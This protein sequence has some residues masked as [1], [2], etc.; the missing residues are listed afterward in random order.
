MK[1]LLAFGRFVLLAL[2]ATFGSAA[3]HAQC[4]AFSY[5]QVYGQVQTCTTGAAVSQGQILSL[6]TSNQVVP[7]AGSATT[8]AYG[9]A[10]Q[11]GSTGASILILINGQGGV[12]VDGACTVGQQ[13]I[14][15]STAGDGHCTSSATVQ[16]VGVA[17][18]ATSSAASVIAQVSPLSSGNA[19]AGSGGTVSSV[20]GD[21][22][23]I[24]NSSSTG[25]V[26]LA[27]GTTAP[28]LFFGN[29]TGSTTGGHYNSLG[30]SDYSP[31]VYVAGGG[32]AQAQT[33]TLPTPATA[34][35]AGLSFCWKPTAANTAA[36]P[37]MAVNGLTA[38]AITKYGTTALA[39]NDLTTTAVAC[40]V[41]DGTEFQLQN[42]QTGS[43]GGVVGGTFGASPSSGYTF[44]ST[45][46]TTSPFS[47]DLLIGTVIKGS[48]ATTVTPGSGWTIALASGCTIGI[49]YQVGGATSSYTA[50]F[51]QSSASVWAS[52]I[53]AFN[54]TSPTLAQSP[55]C[56]TGTNAVSTGSNV[57][58]GQFGFAAFRY[59]TSTGP[60]TAVSGCGGTWSLIG[61]R[62]LESAVKAVGDGNVTEIWIAPNLSAGA[63]TVT[64]TG[65][66]GATAE[67]A[68]SIW[69]G[70]PSSSYL[71]DYAYNPDGTGNTSSTTIS[72]ATTNNQYL[73]QAVNDVTGV[74]DV[75]GRDHAAVFRTAAANLASVGGQLYHKKGI[76]NGQ[77]SVQEVNNSQTNWYVFALPPTASGGITQVYWDSVGETDTQPSSTNQQ[78]TIF[79][80]LPST[81]SGPAPGGASLSVM[82]QRPAPSAINNSVIFRN[83]SCRIPDNQRTSTICFDTFEAQYSS[84]I[85]TMAETTIGY[86][87]GVCSGLTAAAA[88]MVGYRSNQALTNEAYFENTWAIGWNTP[89]SVQSN[90]P[91]GV[92]MHSLCNQ[93]A[94]S[95]TVTGAN[96]G[97]EVM[98]FQDI[99][100]ISG[101]TFNCTA[102]G[103]RFIFLGMIIENES[104]GSF[105]RTSQATETTPGNCM[106]KIDV[107]TN[108]VSA[109]GYNP[110]NFF[111]AG[112][113]A[114][115]RV[116]EAFRLLQPGLVYSSF[117]SA[118]TTGTTKQTLATYPFPYVSTGA[119][120]LGPFQNNSGAVFEI[121]AWGITAANANSKTYEIDFGGTA[122]A[123]I[124]STANAGTIRC[125]ARIIVS[126]VAN[127]Q[128]IEGECDDGTTRTVTRIAPGITGSATIVLNIAA[129]TGTASGDFTFKGLTVEYIGGQ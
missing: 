50:N 35:T 83:M 120:S 115:F 22:S 16:I 81:Y 28:H 123:T 106:G 121:V 36:A 18:T 127:T 40:V 23:L 5:S 14:P 84:H 96:Y 110:P 103:T 8:G 90:H 116:N 1:K 61:L 71:V 124:T 7:L 27:L 97:G 69:T 51:T 82:Y 65:I 99:H 44:T 101:L 53:S 47:G 75:S 78:G 2:L 62:A 45:P 70:V 93:N 9:I 12:S 91:Y 10:L 68:I 42:P 119:P 4:S 17:T 6:N 85:N 60:I 38:T 55:V 109:S 102:A 73:Y 29:N 74:V 76:Y 87:D 37:T 92:N 89:Y 111:N 52:T 21:G 39:A 107:M 105:N 25:A 30:A 108:A 129:T 80:A 3:A 66:S 79:N 112:S 113:G 32:T 20:S 19:N 77:T 24:T 95:F 104:T 63:C 41:Y 13:I 59:T 49:E 58:A 118:A 34:L 94:G 43:S 98:H 64:A 100:N 128:E 72:G 86:V 48:D 122:I 126:S 15:S 54:A 46:I 88:N 56:A 33:A 31:N 117:T 11:S 67:S 114:N 26:T 125:K 57:S